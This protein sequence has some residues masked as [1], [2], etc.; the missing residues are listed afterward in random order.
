MVSLSTELQQQLDD[1]VQTGKFRS[2]EEVIVRALAA[3][4]REA[5]LDQF[6]QS[7]LDQLETGEY[8]S[9]D[10]IEAELRDEYGLK[11]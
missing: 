2:S 8:R 3:L 10:E 5:E 4:R 6:L 9:L 1:L 11:D 7:G